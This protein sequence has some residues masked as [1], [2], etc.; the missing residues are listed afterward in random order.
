V[1][2]LLWKAREVFP[3]IEDDSLISLRYAERLLSGSGLTWTDGEKVEGYSNLL[4]IL[5]SAA[6][7]ALG[8]DLITAVRVLGLGCFVLTFAGITLLHPPRGRGGPL[9]ALLANTYL[10][11]SGPAIV[12]S[13]AGL[14]QPLVIAL[15]AIAASRI[16][17][18]LDADSG[19]TAAPDARRLAGASLPLA[20]L[21]LTRPDAPLFVAIFTAALYLGSFGK[22]THSVAVR[23]SAQL[24]ALPALTWLGQMGFRLLY[25]RDWLPNPAYIKVHVT[26]ARVG[27]GVDYVVDGV[28][29]MWP[30]VALGAAGALVSLLTGKRRRYA[31]LL[32]VLTIAWTGYVALIGGDHFPAHR[33]LLVTLVA[34]CSLMALGIERAFVAGRGYAAAAVVLSL[35]PLQQFVALQARDPLVKVAIIAR[36]Q[37]DGQ[38]VGELFGHG[39]ARQRPLW[40]VTAAGC[41]P[42]F[43]RLPAL[44]MLGLNDRH[45]AHMPAVAGYP[46]AHD[47]GDGRYVLQRKPDLITFGLPL[48]GA[49]V[50]ASGDQMRTDPRFN[51]D[52]QLVRFEGLRPYRVVTSAYV[53]T[54][55][56]IGIEADASAVRYPAYLLLGDVMGQLV[57]ERTMGARL[58]GGVPTSTALIKLASGNWRA[59]VDPPNPWVT[60]SVDFERRGAG[61][62]QGPTLSLKRA[63]RMRIEAMASGADTSV[64]A[65]VIERDEGAAPASDAVAMPTLDASVRPTG[66]PIVRDATPPSQRLSVLGNF[67]AGLG[68][69]I[70][71]GVANW[72]ARVHRPGQTTIFGHSGSFIDSFDPVLGDAATGV[73]RSPTFAVPKNAF[74]SLRVAGGPAHDYVSQVGVRLMEGDAVRHVFT[75][76]KTERLQLVRLDL[77][78]YAGHRMYLEIFDQA[79]I[80]WGH[81]LVDE[82]ELWTRNPIAAPH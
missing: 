67:D 34:L 33:H 72:P 43:S 26:T 47:H 38:V 57:G 73:L 55:G 78:P 77:S 39:F 30:L 44:D 32:V 69:W 28:L 40:A 10:A 20:L 70:G 22:T 11:L 14:E 58:R 64:G 61:T 21:V 53:R 7:G 12:W 42:Y 4:W 54:H 62:A 3:F 41:L 71:H 46:L 49:P 27:S 80:P 59:R 35:A 75:G 17:P 82:V 66:L 37:W 15:F 79:T 13:I 52:Y 5:L 50:F 18:L 81:V 16:G 8:M 56:A 19:H 74:L 63:A 25:Y 36:W 2:L 48:G 1:L 68:S 6:L 45:I 24:A 60:L 31:L 65:I 51:R 76:D 23:R 9:P 29:V